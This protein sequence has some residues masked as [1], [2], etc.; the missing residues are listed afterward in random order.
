[1]EKNDFFYANSQ[2]LQKASISNFACEKHV[3]PNLIFF[4]FLL[5]GMANP[6]VVCDVRAPYSGGL[7]F[8]GYFCTIL[9]PGHP[10]THPPKIT[11][12][13]EGITPNEDVKCKGVR[14][15]LNG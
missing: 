7:T 10:A 6:S 5:Y 3:H 12:I 1:M 8:P 14:K 4:I 2:D 9:Y 15:K 13:V 11:K